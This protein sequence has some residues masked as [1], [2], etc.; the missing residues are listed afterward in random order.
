MEQ[1]RKQLNNVTDAIDDWVIGFGADLLKYA[2]S[3]RFNAAMSSIRT[4]L[5]N[6][7]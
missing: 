7:C 1:I 6:F 3:N 5:Q 4:A 2:V